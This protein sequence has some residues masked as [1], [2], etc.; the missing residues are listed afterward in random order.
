MPSEPRFSVVIPA[1]NEQAYLPRLLASL[2]AASRNFD[3]GT[4]AIEIIVADNASTDATAEIARNRGCLVVPVAKRLIAAARNGGARAA[5]GEILCFVDADMQVHRG[6]F[7]AIETAINT[8]RFIAGATG[9]RP[10][11]WSA[12]IAVTW[13]LL[14]PGVRLLGLDTGVVFCRREDYAAVGG[15]REDRLCAEDVDFLLALKRLGRPL[16]RGFIRLRSVEAV[17]STRKFDKH[18]DWHQVPAMVRMAWNHAF[19]RARFEREARTY[20]YEDR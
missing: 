5:R 7:G 20:W 17:M 12:G 6:T 4:R 14:L 18:G 1:Y 11:R 8:G 16:G 19:A 10:E 3:R 9:V 15:Y 13:A 2:E